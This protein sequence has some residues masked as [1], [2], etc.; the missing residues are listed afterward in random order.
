MVCY[1]PRLGT[2][3]IVCAA[4]YALF[5][6]VIGQI[7]H[8]AGLVLQITLITCATAAAAGLVAWTA[9]TIQ[10]RRAAAGAC[11]T[12]RFRCQQPLDLRPQPRVAHAGHRVAHAGHRQV[13]LLPVPSLPVPPPAQPS[14]VVAHDGYLLTPDGVTGTSIS[15]ADGETTSPA[16][17]LVLD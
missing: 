11:T 8:I 16:R 10:R 3:A 12:C 6:Q 2:I 9:R 7:L 5:H 13:V 17:P 14:A 4:A 15:G 1:G